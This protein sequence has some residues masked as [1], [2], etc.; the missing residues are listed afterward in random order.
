MSKTVQ[1][2]LRPTSRD[3]V[4]NFL[5]TTKIQSIGMAAFVAVLLYSMNAIAAPAE[6]P[7]R[8]EFKINTRART[9]DERGD[10]DE[11]VFERPEAGQ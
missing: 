2:G 6:G 10:S 3:K 4:G 8:T 7:V 9:G 5:K 1:I 11:V